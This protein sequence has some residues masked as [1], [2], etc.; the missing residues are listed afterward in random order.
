MTAL[1]ALLLGFVLGMSAAVLLCKLADRRRDLDRR[2]LHVCPFCH[3]PV[4]EPSRSYYLY[5]GAYRTMC[6]NC[7]ALGP[8]AD[9]KEEALRVWYRWP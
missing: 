7:G 3:A 2:E 5:D 1:Y 6:D 9:S 8:V 4:L